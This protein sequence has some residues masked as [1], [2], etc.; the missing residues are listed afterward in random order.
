VD[1]IIEYILI[2]C[3]GYAMVLNPYGDERRT[4]GQNQFGT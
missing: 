2:S 4:T 3:G 1:F